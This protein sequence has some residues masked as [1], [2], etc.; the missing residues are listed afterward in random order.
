[1][2]T[3]N[4]ATKQIKRLT[5]LGFDSPRGLSLHGMDVV[6]SSENSN[7]LF[8]YLVN[9]RPLLV[10]NPWEAGADESI[11]VFKTQVGGDSMTHMHTFEDP[12]ILAPNDV[13]GSGDGE[14]VYFTNDA[15]VHTLVKILLAP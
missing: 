11:E 15:N 12:T 1:V 8:V 10:G 4:P 7:E 5:P 13:V 6:P 2:A 14:S 3:Y 9:H